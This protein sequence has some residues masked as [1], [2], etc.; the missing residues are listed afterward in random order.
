MEEKMIK[1][2]YALF[3]YLLISFN[4]VIAQKKV[5]YELNGGMLFPVGNFAD[6]QSN[7]FEFSFI[8]HITTDRSLFHL[9]AGINYTHLPGKTESRIFSPDYSRINIHWKD[10]EFIKLFIGHQFTF[11]Q[12]KGF[13]IMPAISCSF[14]RNESQWFRSGLDLGTGYF[15]P[16]RNKNIKIDVG[17]KFGFLNLYGKVKDENGQQEKSHNVISVGLGLYF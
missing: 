5:S 3:L 6:I 4:P 17:T 13:Y 1:V 15:L 7:G 12:N 9:I 8:E 2:I 11:L 10:I 14:L 16:I